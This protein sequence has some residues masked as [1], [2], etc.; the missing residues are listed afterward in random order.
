MT[1][2]A[3]DDVVCHRCFQDKVL[4]HWI[5]DEGKRGRCPWCGRAGFLIRLE[6][7]SE[8]FREVASLYVPVEGP[9]AYREGAFISFLLDDSWGVFDEQIQCGDLAQELAVSILY[10][11]LR[12]RSVSTTQTTTDSSATKKIG[13]RTTGMKKP[14]P[15]SPGTCHALIKKGLSEWDALLMTRCP[16]KWKLPLKTWRRS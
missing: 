2:Y 10:A 6:Q 9:N 15:R 7:L 5:R 8:P 1:V 13:L 16:I 12:P 4:R 14:T 11:D 3:R